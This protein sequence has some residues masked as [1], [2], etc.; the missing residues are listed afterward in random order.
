[1]PLME[2][3]YWEAFLRG[4]IRLPDID[5]S[6]NSE[7]EPTSRKSLK[8]ACRRAEALK[9][10][11]ETDQARPSHS[12]WFVKNHIEYLPLVKAMARVIGMERQMG[13]ER[14]SRADALDLADLHTTR[15]VISTSLKIKRDH[16]AA[17]RHGKRMSM[18]EYKVIKERYN[19]S[20]G[21]RQQLPLKQLQVG[22]RMLRV[23]RVS[24]ATRRLSAG[25]YQLR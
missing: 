3:Q 21:K 8:T 15:S 11:Y 9:R 12:V 1:M 5:W 13:F 4:S 19:I 23:G 14:G 25:L 6:V 2:H 20:G 22:I 17:L 7:D 24:V 18:V 10:L 16:E